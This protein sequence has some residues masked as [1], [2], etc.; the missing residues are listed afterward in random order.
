MDQILSMPGRRSILRIKLFVSKPR[1]QEDVLSQ[2]TTVQFNAGRCSPQKVLAD[3]MPE[4][5]GAMM[6]SVCGPGAFA[7]EVRDAVRGVIGGRDSGSVDFEEEAFT[8]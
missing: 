1:T 4:R 5:I 7:D 8:W 6:V 3:V 2:S